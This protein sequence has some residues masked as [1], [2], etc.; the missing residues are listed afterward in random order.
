MEM[1]PGHFGDTPPAASAGNVFYDETPDDDEHGM[2]L[3]CEQIL[4]DGGIPDAFQVIFSGNVSL[5]ATVY[6]PGES[7]MTAIQDAVDAEFPAVGNVYGDRLG[8]LASTAATPASTR[9]GRRRSPRAGTSTTG[10]Q[11]T[12]RRSPPTRRT[13]PTSA[14]SR[15]RRDVGKVINR[16]LA[17]PIGIDDDGHRRPGRRGRDLAAAVRDPPLVGART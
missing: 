6:S 11:A 5:K 3:R 9:W 13:R 17:T 10:R 4:T 12:G 2:Q 14:A 7:A 16:A 15:C 1:H 8:R